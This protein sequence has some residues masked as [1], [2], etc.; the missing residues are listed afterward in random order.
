MVFF[1]TTF[2]ATGFGALG[3]AVV[4]PNAQTAANKTTAAAGMFFLS[5]IQ[6]LLV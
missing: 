3:L 6:P 5:L 4:C 1:A 2:F